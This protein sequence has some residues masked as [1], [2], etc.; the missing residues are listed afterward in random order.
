MNTQAHNSDI[1][2]IVDHLA[3]DLDAELSNIGNTFDADG[4]SVSLSG[5]TTDTTSAPA[6]TTSAPVNDIAAQAKAA[7]ETAKAKTV[8]TSGRATGDS[9]AAAARAIFVKHYKKM[10]RKDVIALFISEANCKP[11][12]AATY[13]QSMT[14]DPKVLALVAARDAAEAEAAANASTTSDETTGE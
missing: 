7:L 1:N 8:G 14:K 4:N 11:A 2:S 3:L 5:D 12:G 10:Q 9:K 13:Y 6:D